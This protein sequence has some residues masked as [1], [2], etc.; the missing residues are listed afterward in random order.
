VDVMKHYPNVTTA[1]SDLANQTSAA[2]PADP[3]EQ[4]CR[5][6]L[7]L[8]PTDWRRRREQEVLTVLLDT[9]RP[10]QR[11]LDAAQRRDLAG[12]AATAWSRTTAAFM[13]RAPGR[14][15]GAAVL[16]IGLVWLTL[17]APAVQPAD[18]AA[19]PR[20]LPAYSLATASA[21][22]SPPGPAVALYQQ[23]YGVELADAPQAVVVGAGGA[24]RRLDLAEGRGDDAQGIQG[25]PAPMLLSPDGR[26]VAVGRYDADALDVA[27]QDLTTGAVIRS[28]GLAGRGVVPL[29]WSPDS[30][31]V[32]AV[33]SQDP[34]IPS[35]GETDRGA[36]G[37][38]VL[39]DN[40]GRIS[41]LAP[42]QLRDPVG[43]GDAR[44]WGSVVKA[45]FSP[46]GRQLVLQDQRG[47]LTVLDLATGDQRALQTSGFLLGQAAWSP[48][49]RWLA[50]RGTCAV[51]LVPVGPGAPAEAMA[52]SA[53]QAAAQ[54]AAEPRCIPG[55]GAG[56][57]FV[58]WA[59]PGSVVLD[60]HAGSQAAPDLQS[61]AAF[62][63]TTGA[64]TVVSGIPTTSGNYAV[65]RLQV[66][67]V[68]L[69]GSLERSGAVPYPQYELQYDHGRAE[70]VLQVLA[71]V[72]AAL[73]VGV[74]VAATATLLRRVQH[75]AGVRRG[76]GRPGL[77]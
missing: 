14:S 10:G 29:A 71:L 43:A 63:V 40:L 11:T 30:L 36:P 55:V 4:S 67:A 60:E 25:E 57:R 31:S 73:G 13:R 53:G 21:S 28:Q 44:D 54:S 20:V 32:L 62:D 59:G 33:V 72:L 15:A 45:A 22:T 9:S 75:L 68:A 26:S 18:P 66:P 41:S 7:R 16:I 70:M 5:R 1:A 64:R 3:L 58:G 19:L 76:G 2:D 34:S 77:G 47:D 51:G 39:V 6:W 48:D 38:P 69:A 23:G 24:V 61:V 35:T 49:G 8:F 74:A 65:S 17:P 42:G 12:A 46:D 37:T 56:S 52:Q 50:V 27:V